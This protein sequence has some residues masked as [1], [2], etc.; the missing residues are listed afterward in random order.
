MKGWNSLLTTDKL[1]MFFLQIDQR[2]YP[3]NPKSK[4][5]QT[6]SL[7][8]NTCFVQKA[9][10][11]TYNAV[12]TDLPKVFGRI[13]LKKVHSS[14]KKTKTCQFLSSKCYCGEVKC[15]FNKPAVF[16]CQKSN[17]FGS[18]SQ[19]KK[20]YPKLFFP[21]KRLIWTLT[22]QFRQRCPK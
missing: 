2:P 7:P 1:P 22:R 18:S 14:S 10:L 4:T 19:K 20:N 9:H 6:I 12:L 5:R 17:F 15:S 3:K 21:K 11:A 8:R 16:L 13:F